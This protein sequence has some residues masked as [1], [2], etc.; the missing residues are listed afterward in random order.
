MNALELI[1]LIP[2][3][4]LAGAV[5]MLL[6]GRKLEHG[7]KNVEIS[8]I[9]P[10]LV[11]VAFLHSAAAVVQ[12]TSVTNHTFEKV[13]YTWVGGLPFHMA[14]GE[15][16][17]FTADFGYMLDPLSAVMVLVV[18]GVGFL[19]H[20]YSIGYMGHEGGFYRFFGYLNLFMFNMLT[21]VLANNYVLLFVG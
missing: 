15:L 4:P 13:L 10:G 12:L 7:H 16:A 19:I 20:V 17:R 6:F 14:S 5:L 18:T 8:V 1:W 11:G 3:Y 2:M 21:L 9:C